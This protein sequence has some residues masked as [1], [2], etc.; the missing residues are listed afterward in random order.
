MP[1]LETKDWINGRPNR[2]ELS[3]R[4]QAIYINTPPSGPDT[5]NGPLLPLPAPAKGGYLFQ[6]VAGREQ[7]SFIYEKQSSVHV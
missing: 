3:V 1:S 4:G 6:G 2:C 5:T 7:K